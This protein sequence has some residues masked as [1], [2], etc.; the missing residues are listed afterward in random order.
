[1]RIFFWLTAV[2]AGLA[3]AP[4]L[5]QGTAEQR[6]ACEGDAYR[7]CDAYVPDAI[8]IE[9]CL[10]AK[11]NSLSPGCRAEFGFPTAAADAGGKKHKR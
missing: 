11:A 2:L 5:A 10:R 8:L 1:M 6:A 4:A 3:A 9:R 7:L